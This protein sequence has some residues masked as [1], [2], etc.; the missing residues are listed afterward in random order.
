MTRCPIIPSFVFNEHVEEILAY[1]FEDYFE[2]LTTYV[3]ALFEVGA[4]KTC[5]HGPM[6]S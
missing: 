3:N 2:I 5:S 6:S 4:C 1:D